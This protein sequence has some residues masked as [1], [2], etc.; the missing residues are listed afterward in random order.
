MKYIDR[1][2]T[3]KS[4]NSTNPIILRHADVLLTFAEAENEVAGPTPAAYAA[5]NKVRAR[6]ELKDLQTVQAGLN[7]DSFREAVYLE[8]RHEFVA[9]FHE[10]FD[11]K[12]QGRWLTAMNNQIP[13]YPGASNPATPTCRPRNARASVPLRATS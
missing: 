9:K 12:R 10:W 1:T 3:T 2:A 11:L 7:K 13:L 8:R 4:Q 5:I 6:A